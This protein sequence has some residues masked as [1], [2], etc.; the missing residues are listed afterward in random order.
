MK[1]RKIGMNMLFSVVLLMAAS[2]ELEMAVSRDSGGLPPDAEALYQA[3][4][5]SSG[6]R[7]TRVCAEAKST[8]SFS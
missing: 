5:V 6:C 4:P 3:G 1:Q 8:G 2:A 7:G